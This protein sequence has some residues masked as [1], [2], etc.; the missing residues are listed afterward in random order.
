MRTAATRRWATRWGRLSLSSESLRKH[1]IKAR[2]AAM[3]YSAGQSALSWENTL[4]G[5]HRQVQQE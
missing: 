2:N 4:W 1:L 3:T 5:M